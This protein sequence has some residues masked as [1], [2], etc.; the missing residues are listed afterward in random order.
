[1]TAAVQPS[2]WPEL[3]EAEHPEHASLD[4][5]FEL[6][7]VLNPHVYDRL[8]DLALDLVRHGRTRIGMKMLFEV[9]RWQQSIETTGD[10]WKLNNSLTSRYARLLAEQEPDLADV[11]ETRVLAAERAA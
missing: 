2:L 4:D 8:R 10:V 11:F 7:H 6:F 9:L 5:R 1:M 3:V